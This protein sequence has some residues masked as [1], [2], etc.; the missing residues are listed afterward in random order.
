MTAPDDVIL[1]RIPEGVDPRKNIGLAVKNAVL[2]RMLGLQP[3]DVQYDHRPP[4]WSRKW[5]ATTNDTVPPA[6][7]PEFI[8]A[9]SVKDHD[10]VTNGRGGERRITSAG[11]DT[12]ARAKGERLSEGQREY[13]ASL[14]RK[15]A[16]EP[17]PERRGTFGS[18]PFRKPAPQ[19][20]A[21]GYQ[22]R[23]S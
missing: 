18:R 13:R 4:L 21:T 3:C 10:T 7:D 14:L 11:S 19:N 16:G 1:D 8:V 22:R 15:D 20:R 9:L 2:L 17:K 5:N 23:N 12:H 6:N